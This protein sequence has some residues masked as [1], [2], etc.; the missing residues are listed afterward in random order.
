MRKATS[1]FSF[2]VDEENKNP[3]M[4]VSLGYDH[5]AE[6]EWGI[7]GMKSAFGF[8]EPK[9]KNAGIKCR[10]ITRVPPNLMFKKDDKGGAVL[11]MANRDWSAIGNAWNTNSLPRDLHGY[12]ERIASVKKY[13]PNGEKDPMISAWDEGSFGIAVVGKEYVDWLEELYNEFQ[14]KNVAIASVR[15]S[16][17]NPFANASLSLLIVD[18]MPDYIT[19]PMLEGDLSEYALED[20]CKKIGLTKLKEKNRNGYKKNKYFMAC[21]PKWIEGETA[22]EIDERKKK[23]NTEFN[24]IIWINYSDDD[25]HYG[26][27]RYEDIKEWLSTPDVKLT[28]V[29]EKNKTKV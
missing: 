11:W 16:G 29:L 15:M 3:L 5:C 12:Q 1:D 14:K 25:D 19:E 10:T 6:H 23:W 27:H 28:E 26:W 24:I 8:P 9:K 7:K 18:R 2:I 13:Y 21:S 17:N 4:G 22:E 20:Y